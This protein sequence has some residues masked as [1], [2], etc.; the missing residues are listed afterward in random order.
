MSAAPVH[1]E[2]I[3]VAG[4]G[5][6]TAKAHK[7]SSAIQ[8]TVPYRVLQCHIVCIHYLV[9]YSML[10]GYIIPEVQYNEK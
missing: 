4:S 2:I 10:Q 5:K 6:R 3:C 8:Y 7:I 1:G 9:P